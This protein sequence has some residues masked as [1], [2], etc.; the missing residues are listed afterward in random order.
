MD[1]S[2][3]EKISK[4]LKISA[5]IVGV[6]LIAYGVIVGVFGIGPDGPTA[7]FGW[8]FIG[9]FV[10]LQGIL[11]LLSN[12]KFKDNLRLLIFYLAATLLPVFI[13][14]ALTLFSI[15]TKGVESFS[16]LVG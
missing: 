13:I 7:T 14:I 10:L 3:Y 16:K 5:K 4:A 9:L 11:Y 8:R 6:I 1:K 12:S 15:I 2:A